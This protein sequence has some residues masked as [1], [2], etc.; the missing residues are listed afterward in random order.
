[1]LKAVGMKMECFRNDCQTGEST[2]F[3][4]REGGGKY[5]TN[6]VIQK[7][8]GRQA[9]GWNMPVRMRL[10]RPVGSA[11]GFERGG[12]CGAPRTH[13]EKHLGGWIP[14]ALG[15]GGGRG[16]GPRGREGRG[17]TRGKG[18]WPAGGPGNAFNCAENSKKIVH[19]SNRL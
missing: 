7:S 8:D 16:S 15:D 17:A 14:Q 12:G 6:D 9:P 18:L 11:G 5:L 4:N 2:G 13:W 19:A 3:L 1:M 10:T